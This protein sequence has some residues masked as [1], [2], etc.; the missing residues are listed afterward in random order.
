MGDE[1]KWE[2]LFGALRPHIRRAML[3]RWDCDEEDIEQQTEVITDALTEG[4]VMFV[5]VEH[6]RVEDPYKPSKDHDCTRIKG[7]RNQGY[8]WIY[9]GH[10]GTPGP[11]LAIIIKRGATQ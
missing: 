2:S 10:I 5:E 8:N 11:A 6:I 3:A 4:I 9:L 7:G 1:V